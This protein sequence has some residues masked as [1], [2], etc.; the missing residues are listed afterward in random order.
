MNEKIAVE[1]HFEVDGTI[2]PIAFLWQ[3]KR[4]RIASLGRRWEKESERHFLVM[5]HDEQVYEL[6][7]LTTECGWRLR[8]RPQDF[9]GSTQAV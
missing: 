3:G 4:L 9:R 1:A 2:R 8:R 7:F 6:V 5:T